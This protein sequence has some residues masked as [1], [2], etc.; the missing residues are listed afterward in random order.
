MAAQDTP[1]RR[2]NSRSFIQ[3]PVELALAHL[4]TS[5]PWIQ[6]T[7]ITAQ[8]LDHHQHTA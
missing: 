4:A 2:L 5:T 7:D 3:I 6:P 1:M 8:V